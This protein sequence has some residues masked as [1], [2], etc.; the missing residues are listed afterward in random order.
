M[1]LFPIAFLAAFTSYLKGIESIFFGF[2]AFIVLTPFIF[3]LN[4]FGKVNLTRL[5]LSVLPP[6]ILLLPIIFGELIS[7]PR[8]HSISYAFVGLSAIPLVLYNKRADRRCLIVSLFINLG[9]L[10][11]FEFTMNWIG[12]D[13]LIYVMPQII[14]WFL[15]ITGIQFLK[16]EGRISEDNLRSA[17]QSLSEAIDEVKMQ[18]EEILAQMEA[19]NANQIQIEKQSSSLK[20]ANNELRKTKLELLDMIDKLQE[21]KAQALEK[22]AESQSI[23]NA[24]NEHYLVAHYDI[25]GRITSVNHK[26]IEL[27]GTLNAEYFSGIKPINKHLE[28]GSGIFG[29]YRYFKNLWFHIL[30]NG[31]ET[32]QI[33]VPVGE[34]MKY[35]SVTLA[36]LRDSKNE[37]ISVMAIGQDIT[38]LIDTNEQIDRMNDELREKIN[39]ISQQNQLLNFQQKEIFEINEKLHQQSE[40]I[41]AINESLEERVKERTKVLEEKNMQLAEYAF[42]NSHVLRA[43]VST[44]MGLI[45]LISYSNL[46]QED[47]KVYQ[48]LLDTAKV[49]DNIVHRINSA[50]DQGFHFNRN[51]LEPER[52][53]HPMNH[54]KVK[55]KVS[56]ETRKDAGKTAKIS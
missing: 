13:L 19:L 34:K 51:Y 46:S 45:N 11:V 28:A 35:F 27:F 33:E 29:K 37:P 23:I 49:L 39:E 52:E 54:E 2:S 50:I 14:L 7:D 44:M 32:L 42:I 1:L 12:N 43:P 20:N 48:H 41:K 38:R 3:L 36:P 47:Q 16:K 24:L 31:S 40:E 21:A 55:V 5:L 15:I 9:A 17:N 53:F 8:Y 26:I 56:R 25:E 4:Y 30:E 22:Q 10:L 18:R 6:I